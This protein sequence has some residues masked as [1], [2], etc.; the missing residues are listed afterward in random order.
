MWVIKY[1]KIKKAT[2]GWSSVLSMVDATTAKFLGVQ[3]FSLDNT[4]VAKLKLW[5]PVWQREF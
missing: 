3:G 1:L 5:T 2:P 4:F